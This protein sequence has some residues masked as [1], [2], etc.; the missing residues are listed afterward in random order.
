M[1]F[2]RGLFDAIKSLQAQHSQTSSSKLFVFEQKEQKLQNLQK[3][4]ELVKK[5]AR[6]YMLR[7]NELNKEL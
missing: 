4:L 2:Y 7:W 5:Q 3:E 1:Q 6:E